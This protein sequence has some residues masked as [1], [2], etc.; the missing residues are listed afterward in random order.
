MTNDGVAEG[1]IKTTLTPGENIE[2]LLYLEPGQ[3]KEAYYL[4]VKEPTGIHF[5]TLS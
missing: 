4:T 2:K 5:N 3:T 1:V